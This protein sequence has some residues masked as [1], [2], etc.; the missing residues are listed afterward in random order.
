VPRKGHSYRDHDQYLDQLVALAERPYRQGMK[1]FKDA[2]QFDKDLDMLIQQASLD[3]EDLAGQGEKAKALRTVFISGIVY[4]RMYGEF[5]DRHLV[6]RLNAKGLRVITEP[7]W[8][9]IRYFFEEHMNEIYYLPQ[10]PMQVKIIKGLSAKRSS[11]IYAIA[12]QRHPWL[13]RPDVPRM[14]Q[15]ARAIIDRYFRGETQ[16]MIGS[17]ILHWR[18]KLCDGIVIVGP[19]G[20]PHVLIAESLL[21]H[22][23]EIPK[24][25]VY[26]DGT[27][28]LESDLDAFAYRLRTKPSAVSG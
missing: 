5:I 21:R 23:K 27:P 9:V 11:R 2:A 14:L 20:C 3:F 12:S 16:L 26:L 6:R 13:H 25:F 24:Q 18:K 17:S 7:A 19:W 4:S 10:S 8:T 22:C 28:P 15:E 1:A